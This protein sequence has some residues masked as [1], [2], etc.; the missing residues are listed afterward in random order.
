[1]PPD[2][3][4]RNVA[5]VGV[6]RSQSNNNSTDDR[7]GRHNKEEKI[8][9]PRSKTKTTSTT[10]SM[11]K[12]LKTFGEHEFCSYGTLA[13]SLFF[14]WRATNRFSLLVLPFLPTTYPRAVP[15]C[16]HFFLLNQIQC[17]RSSSITEVVVDKLLVPPFLQCQIYVSSKQRNP[18]SSITQ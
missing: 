8:Q 9:F 4:N 18:S 2:T 12:P 16:T 11:G 6:D 13:L 3:A 7:E 14:A 1:M 17:S 10:T 5:R 15:D